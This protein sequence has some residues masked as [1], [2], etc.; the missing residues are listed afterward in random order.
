MPVPCQLL[1]VWPVGPFPRTALSQGEKADPH[2]LSTPENLGPPRS[3][4][5]G[6]RRAL[7]RPQGSL[8]PSAHASRSEQVPTMSPQTEPSQRQ[9]LL[10]FPTGVP[11]FPCCYF[12]CKDWQCSLSRRILS[13]EP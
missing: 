3:E 9:G 5:L 6:S 11:S 10:F 4:L 7:L 1:G 2:L 12:R 8:L 13:A